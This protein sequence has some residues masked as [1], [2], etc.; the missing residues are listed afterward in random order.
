MDKN[1][2]SPKLLKSFNLKMAIIIVMSAIIG[3]GVFKKVAPMADLL[4]APWLVVLAWLMAGIIIMCGV[5][6]IAELGAM[7]PH[8]GGAYS[9]LEKIY[10]KK[11]GFLYGW[12]CFTVIQTA[13]ISS[14][15]FVFSG[16]L[17]T[18]INLPHLPSEWAD[19]NVLGLQPFSNIGAKFA[20]CILIIALTFVNIKGTKKGGN[21][22]LVFTFLITVSILL[23]TCVAFTNDVGSIH[24][25]ETVSKNYPVGGF[26]FIGFISAMV[27]A[28]RNAFWGYEGWIALGFI[29]EEIK[30]PKKN[31][32]R[33]LIIGISSI[34]LLYLLINSAY[35][36]VM[37]IDE[38]MVS[39]RADENNIA[40][41]L[42]INKLLG[43]GGAYIISGMILISTFGCTN[44]TI[45]VSSRI[46]YAMA[47]KG[48]FFKKAALTHPKNKTPHH[49]LKY[50]CIWACILVFSGSFDMLT[51]ML[52]I[53]GFLFFGLVVLGVILL[54]IKEKDIS[55]PYKM[56]GYPV[57]PAVFVLFCI[58]L[59]GISLYESPGKS[60][61][62]IGL[63]FS[64]FPFYYYWNK[65]KRKENNYL[66]E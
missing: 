12:A 57:V 50:Q 53:V 52:I 38:M 51:D 34:I 7:F 29:G 28:I 47:K 37:P 15:A 21:L 46:Y 40:A 23:I 32:P 8:S 62:G 61:I 45:L 66:S 3:S 1:I 19:I 44:A 58:L 25:F 36:Y 6:S 16:A 60:L 24:T 9:W 65:K 4:H 35:L 55:R 49:S 10:G 17:G 64:G 41:V 48:F 14:I 18:F 42:V 59:L 13:A 2:Q 56:P 5:L 26:T 63:V 11:L 20:S 33:A 27:L 22:S 31:L 54:R 43:Q 30:N 39:I